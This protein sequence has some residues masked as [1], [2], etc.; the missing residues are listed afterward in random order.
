VRELGAFFSNAGIYLAPLVDLPA[1]E[2][3]YLFIYFTFIFVQLKVQ[4]ILSNTTVCFTDRCA[5]YKVR[6]KYA[7][8]IYMASVWCQKSHC[9]TNL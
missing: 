9:F 7:R 2:K 4:A 6:Q 3:K 1:F 8:S 5:R